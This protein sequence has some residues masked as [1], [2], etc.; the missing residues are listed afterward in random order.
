MQRPPSSS[1]KCSGLQ[2][3]RRRSSTSSRQACI[4]SRLHEL[5]LRLKRRTM[6]FTLV[7]C[8]TFV[9]NHTGFHYTPD[10]P[11]SRVVLAVP[12]PAA[13]SGR[14]LEDVKAPAHS[15]RLPSLRTMIGEKSI[16]VFALSRIDPIRHSSDNVS[17]AAELNDLVPVA[18]AQDGFRPSDQS[19]I[20][21]SPRE[22]DPASH[23]QVRASPP[24]LVHHDFPYKAT[25]HVN[26]RAGPSNAADVLTVLPRGKLVRR[27]GHDVGWMQ[28]RYTGHAASGI[29]GW[30]YSGHLEAIGDTDNSWRHEG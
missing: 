13:Q 24:L 14:P 25:S 12:P 8:F 29:T 28:V 23:L 21:C 16:E 1:S 11:V 22:R 19:L 4:D 20:D 30:V 10:A 7:L 6:A 9:S 15:A 3:Q 27:T 2:T 17:G 5:E 18:Y 26:I